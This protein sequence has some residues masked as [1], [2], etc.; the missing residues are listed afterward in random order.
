MLEEALFLFAGIASG[1]AMITDLNG[2][3][4]KTADANGRT[5]TPEKTMLEIAAIA[6]QT[7][8]PE[9]GFSGTIPDAEIWSIPLGPYILTLCN[10]DT[11][12]RN[13]NF[14]DSLRE[15]LPDIGRIVGG[16]AVLFDREGQ[17]L[18]SVNYQGIPNNAF[19]GRISHAAKKTMDTGK[20]HVGE[21]TTVEGA[22]A[23]RIPIT[24]WFGLG[25]NNEQSTHYQR[26][27]LSEVR[28]FQSAKYRFD[29][30]IGSSEVM[31][32]TVATIRTVAQSKSTVLLIGET[33]T[34]KELFAQ[35]IHNESVRRNKPFVA[36]NCG[37]M[38]ES[39]IE[40]YLFG[41]V[42]G[43]FTGAKKT[44]ALGAFEQANGGTIFLDEL[45]EMDMDLQKKILRVIEEK[46]ITRLGSQTPISLDIRIIA[47]TNKDLRNMVKENKFREDLYFRF[48]IL[49]FVLPALRERKEDIPE[50]V[51]CFIKKYN[52]IIGRH[53][54][55]ADDFFYRQCNQYDWP[56]NVREL[57]NYVEFAMNLAKPDE[58]CLRGELLPSVLKNEYTYGN[59][60]KAQSREEVPED[61]NNGEPF[62]DAVQTAERNI[63]LET[64][65]QCA[66][67]KQECARILG[68]SGAT[69]WR[70]MNRLNIQAEKIWH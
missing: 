12:I 16:E 58:D 1:Q 62:L 32:S 52:L 8:K 31:R 36:I 35:S 48:S 70:K 43:S 5:F 56:G 69:L 34:G 4:L 37:A 20:P 13:N 14:M 49:E 28:K 46:E 61:T 51:E 66:G 6:A 7:G 23:I 19:I 57:Q 27:L 55:K 47:S 26:K 41:Y 53:I 67:N 39:L 64:L 22:R 25:M 50:L 63:I 54:K 17:R 2:K 29:D 10:C 65:K 45:G 18:Y 11:I 15:V 24:P 30:I 3:C 44:G 40:S 59:L 21:S 42:E 33:G 9:T 68:I 38:P 60:L